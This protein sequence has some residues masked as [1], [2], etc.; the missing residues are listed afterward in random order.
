MPHPFGFERGLIFWD[1]KLQAHPVCFLPQPQISR[2][3]KEPGAFCWKVLLDTQTW[4]PG[5][6][7]AWVWL[8]PGPLGLQS[9]ELSVRAL[10]W[11]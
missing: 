3:S 4:A 10:T 8:L 1:E 11:A 6:L 9:R 7:A 2:F 5:V